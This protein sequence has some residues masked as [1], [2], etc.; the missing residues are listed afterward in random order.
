MT[1][2]PHEAPRAAGPAAP[3]A[4]RA[5]LVLAIGYTA[6]AARPVLMPVVIALLLALLLRPPVTWLRRVRIPKAVSAA[7]LLLALVTSFGFAAWELREPAARWIEQAPHSLTRLERKLGA[8]RGPMEKVTQAAERVEEIASGGE[9]EGEGPRPV[10]VEEPGVV[11]SAVAG[12]GHFAAGLL[13]TLVLVYLLLVFD[14]VLLGRVVAVL[15]R[16]HD[17]RRAVLIARELEQQMSRYLFTATVIN[18]AEGA[19][20]GAALHLIGVPNP[21]LW[22]AMAAVV[23]FVPYLGA[24][25]GVAVVGGV[26]LLTVE[27]TAY[28]LLAPAS[29][30][31][32]NFVEGMV[33]SPIVLGR[34]FELNP[35]MVFV[36]LFFWGWLWGIGGAL[37]AVPLLAMTKIVCD[38]VPALA[39]VGE[40]LGGGRSPPPET[41]AA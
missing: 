15:P 38:R 23:N 8:F 6:Y 41:A 4:V 30:A 33:I 31:A 2:S 11:E 17:R 40:L 9:E 1:P 20:V 27:P 18:L 36:W 32:I 39:A 10:Q 16:L 29:Y 35:V 12:L 7:V 21:W 22:G 3:P 28:A 13:V 14:E 26:A 24:M 37:I 19:A 5:L 25:V 34:R